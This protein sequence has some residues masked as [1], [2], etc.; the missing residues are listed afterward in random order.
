MK[1]LCLADTN[2]D[3]K[4]FLRN[5]TDSL[6]D[7]LIKI[8]LYSNLQECNPWKRE[9]ASVL[10]WV[11]KLKNRKKYPSVKLILD[12]TWFVYEDILDILIENIVEDMYETPEPYDF[13]YIYNKMELYFYW[14]AENLSKYGRVSREDIFNKLDELINL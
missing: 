8:F 14:L 4:N 9:V 3:V 12:R 6:F 13:D 7:H 2:Q 1:I 10:S 11:P 5:R